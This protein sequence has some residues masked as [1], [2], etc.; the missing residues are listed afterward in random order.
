MKELVEEVEAATLTRQDRV[1]RGLTSDDV[2]TRLFTFLTLSAK[3]S[4]SK[5][6]RA[7]LWRTPERNRVTLC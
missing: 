2:R 1:R 5:E 3:C 4:E 7:A 6:T